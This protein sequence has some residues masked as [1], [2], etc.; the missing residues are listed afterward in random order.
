MQCCPFIVFEGLDGAGTTTQAEL[1]KSRLE[2]NDARRVY[3]T[4]E[5]SN[6]PVGNLLRLALCRRITLDPKAMALL[7]AADRI[8][9]LAFEII[10]K[11]SQDVTVI[12]DRYYLSSFAYQLLDAPEDLEWLEHL[13]AKAVSPD[14]TILIDVPAEVCMERIQ[15]TRWH[16]E[17]FETF[18]Q[19]RAVR[20]N[21]LS[22]ARGPRRQNDVIVVVDGNQSRERVHAEVHK[23]VND[24]FGV[25][26]QTPNPGPRVE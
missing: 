1:L 5:P 11:L 24:R 26:F 20:E 22:L 13:N 12:C 23:I 2:E 19:Q 15:R 8:D 10:E 21:F 16:A 6:G 14:L 4:R 3:L 7:F 9:H 18:E 25:N 17:L